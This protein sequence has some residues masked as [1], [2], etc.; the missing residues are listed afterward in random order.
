[1]VSDTTQKKQKSTRIRTQRISFAT[2]AIDWRD[3]GAVTAVRSQGDCGACWAITAVESVESAHFI[4][5]GD[6]YDLS[7][8]EIITCEDSCSMCSG[9]WPQNAFEWVMDH[10]GLP[11]YNNFPYDGSSLLAMT[12]GIEG[13]SYSWT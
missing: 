5:T 1:M 10:G 2:T 8:A 13:T 11:L 6:L 9:G 4:A 3:Y 7:E 12:Q